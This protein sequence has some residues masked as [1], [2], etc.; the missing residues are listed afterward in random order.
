MRLVQFLPVV[1]LRHVFSRTSLNNCQQAKRH[2]T[3]YRGR[4]EDTLRP[5]SSTRV[6]LTGTGGAA[7]AKS[8][9]QKQLLIL[10]P[11]MAA[12]PWRQTMDTAVATPVPST[13]VYERR[14]E[15]PMLDP[16][17]LERP[18]RLPK[19]PESWRLWK[20]RVTGWLGCV[21]PRYRALLEEAANFEHHITSVNSSIAELDSFLY[22][23]LLGWLE[24]EQLEVM[25]RG[26]EGA[27][28]EAWRGL[29]Q[30][31]EKL[32]PARKVLMLEKLLHPDFGEASE[33]RRRWL[34][35][36]ATILHNTSLVGGALSDEVRIS[37][38]RQRAPDELKRHLVLTARDYGNNYEQ[39]R[40]IIEAYWKALEPAERDRMDWQLE[41]VETK[42]PSK[43]TSKGDLGDR[44][45]TRGPRCYHCGARGH[46]VR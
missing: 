46:V 2:F 15:R 26:P 29:V 14:Q 13:P 19:D 16:R 5:V 7:A 33:W 28:F 30:Q 24:G 36:E 39:F 4:F 37:V 41:L 38:V 6:S 23:Q 1:P 18:E 45:I 12:E 40:A 17:L 32:E 44:Q 11:F 43:G 25:M 35:W 21:D 42:R 9:L 27:G 8:P 22:N 31:Q 3:C 34:N 20:L 10:E